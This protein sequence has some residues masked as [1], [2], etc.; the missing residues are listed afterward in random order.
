ML[1]SAPMPRP[2]T[3]QEPPDG[4]VLFIRGTPQSLARKLRAAAALEGKGLPTYVLEVL[5]AH[6]AELERKGKLPKAR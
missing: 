4:T 6:V 3:K 1:F 5:Q 2:K